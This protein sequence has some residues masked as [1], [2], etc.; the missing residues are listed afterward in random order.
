VGPAGNVWKSIIILQNQSVFNSEII[1]YVISAKKVWTKASLIPYK[2]RKVLVH[3]NK[4]C[5]IFCEINNYYISL[6]H[7]RV[8]VWVT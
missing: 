1:I 6:V 2:V 4:L 3:G 5:G 7:I 8:T